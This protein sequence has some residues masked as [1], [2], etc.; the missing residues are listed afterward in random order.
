MAASAI[1]LVLLAGSAA[2]GGVPPKRTPL[3]EI[4]R[5]LPERNPMREAELPLPDRNPQR[6]AALP[7]PERN[8]LRFVPEA[9]AQA[10]RGKGE[11]WPRLVPGTPEILKT[12]SNEEITAERA[13]CAEILKGIEAE[14]AAAARRA[15]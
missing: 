12:W 8:P 2:A 9:S 13:R 10:Q 14:T 11:H 1:L 7:L 15:P 5:P 6:E 3:R 4:G